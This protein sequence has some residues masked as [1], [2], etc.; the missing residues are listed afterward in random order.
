MPGASNDVI[1]A[2][3]LLP[4]LLAGRDPYG[5]STSV[6][7]MS[8]PL[9]AGIVTLPF[10]PFTP[11]IAGGLFFGC[12]SALLA[13]GLT[14]HGEWWRLMTFLSYPYWMALHTVQWSP[15]LLAIA[16][17]PTLLPITLAKPHIG[18]PIAL[19]HLTPRR[20][21]ACG[22]LGVVSLVLLP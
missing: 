4:D 9:T 12:S 16:F 21:L 2:I 18:L 5:Y 8:Y 11:I 1:W 3:R 14:H 22:V 15:L 6:E 10:A 19:T 20:A 17:L 13:F 7:P